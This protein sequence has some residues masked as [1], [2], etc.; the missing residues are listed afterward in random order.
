MC[1]SSTA[2]SGAVLDVIPTWPASDFNVLHTGGLRPACCGL[3]YDSTVGR[4][5]QGRLLGAVTEAL[6]ADPDDVGDQ[7]RAVFGALLQQQLIEQCPPCTLPRIKTQVRRP[8]RPFA[9]Q[10]ARVWC[11]YTSRADSNVITAHRWHAQGRTRKD[12][13]Q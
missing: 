10:H 7:L 3:T 12:G 2:A 11:C 6:Q 8:C 4:V 13:T 5:Q 1:S 9:V